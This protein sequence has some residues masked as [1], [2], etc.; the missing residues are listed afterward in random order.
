MHRMINVLNVYSD[1]NPQIDFIIAAENEKEMANVEKI[2]EEAYTKWFE[3]EEYPHLQC[4]A[5]GDYLRSALDENSILY[6][7]YEKQIEEDV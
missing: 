2:I 6:E 1:M 3:L 7:W 5:I 4:I